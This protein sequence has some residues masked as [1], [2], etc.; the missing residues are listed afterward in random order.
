MSRS[1]TLTNVS[2]LIGEGCIAF[3]NAKET[4]L[5]NLK[6]ILAPV[7]EHGATVTPIG[8]QSG[9]VCW[10]DV[11]EQNIRGPVTLIRVQ[12]GELQLFISE[13]AAYDDP[14]FGPSVNICANGR[15]YPADEIVPDWWTLLNLLEASLEN[16]ADFYDNF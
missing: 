15:W 9:A 10:A 2:R 12:D 8:P 3:K 11:P 4:T 5:R 6:T 1:I 7:G 14:E 13:Y 16:I